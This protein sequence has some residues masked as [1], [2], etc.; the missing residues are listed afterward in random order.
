MT[1]LGKRK[2]IADRQLWV[3]KGP[4]SLQIHRRKAVNEIPIPESGR[5]PLSATDPQEPLTSHFQMAAFRRK[6]A[7]LSREPIG[8]NF[9]KKK[10]K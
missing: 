6:A 3:A 4:S 7:S 8:T 10:L 5:S 2:I 1:G 9:Q